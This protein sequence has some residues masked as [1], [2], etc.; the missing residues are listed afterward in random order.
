MQL[1]SAHAFFN[2][3]FFSAELWASQQ[4]VGPFA[5]CQRRGRPRRVTYRGHQA[6]LVVLKGALLQDALDDAAAIGVAR[7]GHEASGER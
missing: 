3:C 2:S 4:Y 5:C 7:Q 1:G 6:V